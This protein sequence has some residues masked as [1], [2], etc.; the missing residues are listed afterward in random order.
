M[1]YSTIITLTSSDEEKREFQFEIKKKMSNLIE[2]LDKIKAL[3]TEL[4]ILT[5][6]DEL[7]NGNLLDNAVRSLR[8]KI[9]K[10]KQ[11]LE[12]F[13]YYNTPV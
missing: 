4:D 13:D 6:S 12:Q 1:T 11:E 7:G 3:Q 10:L 9:A 5:D 2:A 8:G